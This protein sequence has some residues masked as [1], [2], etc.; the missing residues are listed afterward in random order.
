MQLQKQSHQRNIMLTTLVSKPIPNKSS[1]SDIEKKDEATTSSNTESSITP[2]IEA[3]K[4]KESLSKDSIIE[5]EGSDK[6]PVEK[7]PKAVG[8]KKK[9]SGKHMKKLETA[10]KKCAKQI[11]KLEEA[12]VDW[13]N[14]DDESNYVLCAKYKRRYMQLHKKIAEYK[15]MSSSLDRK[16]DKKFV[17]SESRYPEINKK[18]QKFVNKTKQFPDFQDIRNL[19]LE[20]NKELH[21]SKMQIDDEAEQI[22]RSVG[23]RLKGRREIDETEVLNSYIPEDNPADPASKDEDLNK[24]LVEQGKEG[25]KRIEKY[26]D[27]FYKEHVIN[28]GGDTETTEQTKIDDFFPANNESDKVNDNDDTNIDKQP[29]RDENIEEFSGDKCDDSNDKES[30]PSGSIE[31]GNVQKEN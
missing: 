9:V 6:F 14:E 19:V 25:K 20:V 1:A 5:M 10:L 28:K 15:Q 8:D 16:C 23:K 27:D 29:N 22:F 26:F 18:I 30:L 12:E 17:C 24:I 2:I 3:E 4:E 13:D 21:L 31:E 7:K 11:R